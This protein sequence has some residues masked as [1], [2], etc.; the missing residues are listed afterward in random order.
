MPTTKRH[1]RACRFVVSVFPTPLPLT[2]STKRHPRWCLLV[3]GMSF[4][5]STTR[6]P[7]NHTNKGVISCWASFFRPTTHANHETTPTGVSFRG[8]CLSYTPTTHAEH[9]KTPSL[10]SFGVR[11]VFLMLYYT[12]TTK[13]HQ[14]RCDFVLGI[15]P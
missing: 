12:P 3:F 15:T 13:P 9:E 2:P 14:Q 5:C 1:Q 8:Q 4:L 7:R 11:H 6:P 10:V